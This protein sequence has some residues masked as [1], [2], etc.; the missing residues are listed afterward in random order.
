MPCARFYTCSDV[1][2]I[3]TWFRDRSL[4]TGRGG[5]ATKQG[6]KGIFTPT[7]QGGG[8]GTSF[9]HAEREGGTKCF[10]VVFMW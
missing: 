6:G 7:K 10:G 8:A 4:I 3:T 5:G 1:R 9:S 2:A